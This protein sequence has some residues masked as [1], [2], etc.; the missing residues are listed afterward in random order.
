MKIEFGDK[1]LEIVNQDARS[2]HVCVVVSAGFSEV[3]YGG[4]AKCLHDHVADRASAT[5]YGLA[6]SGQKDTPK[7]GPLASR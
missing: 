1:L 7:P 5:W 2:H 4:R 3:L 6:L